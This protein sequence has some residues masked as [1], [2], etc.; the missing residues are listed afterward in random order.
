M[1][2]LITGGTGTLGE[3]LTEYFL[4]TKWAQRICIYSR[5]EHRQ[6]QMAQKYKEENHRLRF[7]IGDV[8][9]RD[10]LVLAMRDVQLVIHTAAL[11][12]VPTAEYNP[13]EAIKTN[14][15]GAQNVIDAALENN[16]YGTYPKVLAVSTD[17]AVNPINLYG[18]TKLCSEK[19]F[20]AANNIRGVNGPKFSVARYGNV[21][22]SNGSVI[23]LFKRQMAQGGQPTITHP[24]MTRFWITIDEAVHFIVGC[25]DQMCGG[26][27]FVPHMPSFKVTDLA[28][29]MMKDL[30]PEKQWFH[31]SGIRPGEKLHESI[32]TKEEARNT[33]Y[34]QLTRSYI[35]GMRNPVVEGYEPIVEE[36]LTSNS[37]G[38]RLSREQLEIM[39]EGV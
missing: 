8:R 7:F 22:N 14:V 6:E 38:A 10:R 23:P 24:E 15:M 35:I 36:E 17:K 28:H 21:A 4:S 37:I 27:I 20:I 39:L 3:K 2:I 12:I 33:V 31:V 9:D 29:A 26:E 16:H 18:A 13:F 32:I 25:L 11:K 34:H 1:N 5:G 30:V 19:L